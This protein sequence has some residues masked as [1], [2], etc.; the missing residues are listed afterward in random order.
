[1]AAL[2]RVHP[3]VGTLLTDIVG[4]ANVPNVSGQAQDKPAAREL[5]VVATNAAAEL[6][7]TGMNITELA[8]AAGTSER[9]IYRLLRGEHEPRLA[10]VQRVAQA[11]GRDIQWMLTD[12]SERDAA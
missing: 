3:I 6:A 8:A 10:S 7:R 5:T 2:R 4:Q 11:F 9:Q 12:H 1:M